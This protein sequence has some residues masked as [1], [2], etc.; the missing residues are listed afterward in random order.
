MTKE[1]LLNGLDKKKVLPALVVSGIILFFLL[2]ILPLK[3]RSSDLD[4]KLIKVGN[5]LSQVKKIA[6]RYRK[7]SSLGLPT[8]D[9][10]GGNLS[11]VEKVEKIAERSGVSE[12]LGSV[13]PSGK[14]S[15][16]VTLHL[17]GVDIYSLVNFLK[18]TKS[19][20]AGL[21]VTNGKIKTSFENRDALEVELQL[22]KVL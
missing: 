1:E 11:I 2:V 18:I 8:A 21:A 20:G 3:E 5:E 9:G 6:T 7:L 4:K 15:D 13:T 14:K 10:L 12:K 16:T 19:S 17:S 22:K